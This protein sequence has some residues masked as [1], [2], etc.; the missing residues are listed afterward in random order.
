[1]VHKFSVGCE[2]QVFNSLHTLLW[3]SFVIYTLLGK[4][5][6]LTW[7]LQKLSA[8]EKKK[9]LGLNAV[10]SIENVLMLFS[11]LFVI[12]LLCTFYY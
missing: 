3:L 11:F 9:N 10:P 1:M 2:E 6:T 12:H 8:R 7:V 4:S 5:A